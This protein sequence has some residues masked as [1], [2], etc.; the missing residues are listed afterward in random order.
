MDGTEAWCLWTAVCLHRD[1]RLY[2]YVRVR[3]SETDSTAGKFLLFIFYWLCR[4][5]QRRVSAVDGWDRIIL[6]LLLLLPL[7]LLLLW[8]LCDCFCLSLSTSQPKSPLS[9]PTTHTPPVIITGKTALADRYDGG[10]PDCSEQ[11]GAVCICMCVY[12]CVFA[13]KLFCCVSVMPSYVNDW[14]ILIVLF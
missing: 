8:L 5:Q 7:L 13:V 12:M 6:V 10:R 9:P 3:E 4:L 14:L 1:W 2:V 11:M